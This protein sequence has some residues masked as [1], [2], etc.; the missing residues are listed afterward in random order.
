[1]R[2]RYRGEN[3]E[4]YTYTPHYTGSFHQRGTVHMIRDISDIMLCHMIRDISEIMFCQYFS[5]FVFEYFGAVICTI[6]YLK[7]AS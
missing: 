4:W 6:Q 3:R 2:S 1:M 5:V 7:I